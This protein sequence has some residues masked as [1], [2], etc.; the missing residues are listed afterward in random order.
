MGVR[1]E[2]LR[3]NNDEPMY[4]HLA[5]MLHEVCPG[6]ETIY[7]SL[8]DRLSLTDLLDCDN[9]SVNKTVKISGD[10]IVLDPAKG[11]G[12]PLTI[13]TIYDHDYDQ[14]KTKKEKPTDT[15]IDIDIGPASGLLSAHRHDPKTTW[16]VVACDY[17]L[18]TTEALGQLLRE[19]GGELACFRNADGFLEPLLAI[20][21][22]DALRELERNVQRGILGPS[23]V[24]KQMRAK[25]VTPR[26]ERWV[27]NANTPEDWQRALRFRKELDE[28]GPF[29]K[30]SIT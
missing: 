6:S 13:R 29:G 21:T 3:L 17:P 12:N 19:A 2:L 20:W 22:P 26:D 4:M 15:S 16:L 24:V 25:A 11:G 7:L 27:F 14:E 28:A 1:K 18:L 8:R 10:V 5:T 23:A 30:N 9:N